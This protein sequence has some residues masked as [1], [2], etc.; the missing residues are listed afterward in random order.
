MVECVYMEEYMCG[1]WSQWCEDQKSDDAEKQISR[2]QMVR[3]RIKNKTLGSISENYKVPSTIGRRA[4][5]TCRTIWTIVT[6]A[7]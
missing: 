3:D 6:G 7:C 1:Y 5:S 4:G 2:H